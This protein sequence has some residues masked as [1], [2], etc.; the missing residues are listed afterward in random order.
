M[1]RDI[2]E[3][4]FFN[5]PGNAFNFRLRITYQIGVLV[6]ELIIFIKMCESGLSYEKVDQMCRSTEINVQQMMKKTRLARRK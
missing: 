6:K 3:W 2:S 4:F 5:I 1:N